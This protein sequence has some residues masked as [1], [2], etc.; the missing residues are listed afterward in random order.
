MRLPTELFILI[1]SQVQAREDLLN[2]YRVSKE[3]RRICIPLL[4]RVV[5]AHTSCGPS[6][7]AKL[8]LYGTLQDP[9]VSYLVME[10][11]LELRRDSKCMEHS[12]KSLSGKRDSRRHCACDHYDQALGRA[13]RCLR[14]LRVLVMICRLCRGLHTH[15]YLLQV[16]CQ[17]SRNYNSDASDA[18]PRRK[19]TRYQRRSYLHPSGAM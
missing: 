16:E 11:R 7:E 10:L 14:N 18:P 4:Y 17:S 3:F 12:K 9:R 1:A 8:R 5:D 19:V 13:L 2:L 6:F 15:D